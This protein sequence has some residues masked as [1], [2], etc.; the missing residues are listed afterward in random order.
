M[1]RDCD[2]VDDCATPSHSGSLTDQAGTGPGSATGS[3]SEGG[4]LALAAMPVTVPVALLPVTW[5]CQWHYCQWQWLSGWPLPPSSG[6]SS[7]ELTLPGPSPRGHPAARRVGPSP[8]SPE[9][10]EESLQER[11]EAGPEREVTR[12]LGGVAQ[13]RGPHHAGRM[14]AWGPCRHRRWYA[15]RKKEK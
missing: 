10:R 3:A 8:E 11:V 4:G 13:D 6:A 5:H 12:S 15:G 1:S 9:K 7:R 2:C 14:R